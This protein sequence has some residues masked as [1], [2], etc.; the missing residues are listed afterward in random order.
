MQYRTLYQNGICSMCSSAVPAK[1][2]NVFTSERFNKHKKLVIICS[3]CALQ[4]KNRLTKLD[5]Y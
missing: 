1:K 3:K 2:M 4:I 5:S